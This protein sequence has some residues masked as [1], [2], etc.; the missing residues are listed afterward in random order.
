MEGLFV[1]CRPDV[2]IPIVEAHP[3]IAVIAQTPPR[4]HNARMIGGFIKAILVG[5]LVAVIVP[6]VLLA[7]MT[8]GVHM[9][10]GDLRA[11]AII[12]ISIVAI[13]FAVV[14]LSAVIVGLPATLLLRRTDAEGLLPYA[15]IGGLT[16]VIIPL[17]VRYATSGNLAFFSVIGFFSGAATGRTWW[18]V[19]RRRMIDGEAQR[20]ADV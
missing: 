5:T 3:P 18:A 6:L 9:A 12:F 1:H 10:Q 20:Y 8:L 4:Q 13:A 11:A 16:G 7:S 14:G 15:A 19:Y 17:V 2:A